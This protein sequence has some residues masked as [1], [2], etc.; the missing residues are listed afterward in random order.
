MTNA[1]YQRKWVKA[2][3]EKVKKYRKNL[4]HVKLSDEDYE[5]LMKWV[6]KQGTTKTNIVCKSL[7][8]F[9]EHMEI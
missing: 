2:H 7:R 6:N 4:L 9:D 1:E 3:P 5:I 8:L